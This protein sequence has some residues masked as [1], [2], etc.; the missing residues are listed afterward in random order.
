MKPEVARI[1]LEIGRRI[2]EPDS[3]IRSVEGKPA[4]HY[5]QLGK[6][7]FAELRLEKDLQETEELLKRLER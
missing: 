2:S 3:R 7:G 5:P 1:N 6:N 4:S